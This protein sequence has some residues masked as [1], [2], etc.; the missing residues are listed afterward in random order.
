MIKLLKL[1]QL[2]T[3][4]MRIQGVGRESWGHALGHVNT[5]K[6]AA[7]N[8]MQVFTELMHD[9]HPCLHS[10]VGN[11]W[12]Q[13]TGRSA[14]WPCSPGQDCWA[15][16]WTQTSLTR[17]PS[18]RIYCPSTLP[19][20]KARCPENQSGDE[21]SKSS[22]R[23]L[24]SIHGGSVPWVPGRLKEQTDASSQKNKQWAN[25]WSW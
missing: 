15:N 9:T 25:P 19:H 21:Q 2:S 23:G 12:D 16:I 18:P 17:L 13:G 8:T 5:Q 11:R 24:L 4:A 14:V 22:P 3:W 7:A 1:K 6:R 10:P 20:N